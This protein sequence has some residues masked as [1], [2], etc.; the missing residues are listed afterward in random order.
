[1][2]PE[3]LTV[4]EAKRVQDFLDAVIAGYSGPAA[5]LESA[6]G[7]YLV[8]RHLGWRALFVI[9]SKKTIA[10]YER[11]LGIKAQQAFPDH[12][13]SANRSAGLRAPVTQANFWK[14]VSCD[15]RVDKDVR[16]RI[17]KGT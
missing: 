9:H 17:D 6:I 11:V 14:V 10:K 2:N 4:T 1:M 3:P 5:E 7:M 8:G 13:P 16:K 12:G 15:I